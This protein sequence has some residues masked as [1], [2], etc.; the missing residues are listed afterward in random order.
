MGAA[1]QISCFNLQLKNDIPTTARNKVMN[2]GSGASVTAYHRESPT[3]CFWADIL[4]ITSGTYL[5]TKVC[6]TRRQLL[7]RT[8][9]A[10]RAPR[11]NCRPY[12]HRT[13]RLSH[14]KH[15]DQLHTSI[16]FCFASIIACFVVITAFSSTP[17]SSLSDARMIDC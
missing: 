2:I 3:G 12:P 15:L 5:L 13:C 11:H 14:C 16:P 17:P 6:S 8:Y 7:R 9:E 1:V 10:P 4:E